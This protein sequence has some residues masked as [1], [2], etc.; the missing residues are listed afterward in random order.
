MRVLLE[1]DV[2]VGAA[3]AEGAHSRAPRPRASRPVY[4]LVN[5]PDRRRPANVRARLGEVQVPG[6]LFVIKG[7]HRLD[8]SR[9][10]GCRLG[11]PQV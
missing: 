11:V 1:D 8:H 3:Q 5:N 9:H 2:S 4:R 6:E 10:T 7:L